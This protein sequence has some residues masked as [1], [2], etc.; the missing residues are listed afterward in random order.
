MYD[1]IYIKCLEQRNLQRQK[2]DQWLLGV[3][4]GGGWGRGRGR[5][6]ERVI[7]F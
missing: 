1:S 3:G 6:K 4:C 7:S 2:V 5:A